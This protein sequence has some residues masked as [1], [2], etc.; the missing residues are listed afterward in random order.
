VGFFI[1]LPILAAEALCSGV[2]AER[3]LNS[4]AFFS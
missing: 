1:C 3:K 2:S 4:I